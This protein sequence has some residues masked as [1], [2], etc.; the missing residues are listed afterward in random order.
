MHSFFFFFRRW[1][2]NSRNQTKLI[3]HLLKK[4]CLGEMKGAVLLWFYLNFDVLHLRALTCLIIN[5]WFRVLDFQA[6]HTV[7]NY[8]RFNILF[9]NKKTLRFPGKIFLKFTHIFSL[10]LNSK[11][12]IEQF[13]TSITFLYYLYYLLGQF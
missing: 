8:A 6:L 5:K 1:L 10:P 12:K 13:I 9:K 7:Y 3:V 4:N 11:G 2:S